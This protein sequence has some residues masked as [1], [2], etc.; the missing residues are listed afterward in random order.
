VRNKKE[1]EVETSGK[2]KKIEKREKRKKQCP[3]SK[4]KRNL[5]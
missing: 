3:E 1:E 4:R 5:Q 2:P